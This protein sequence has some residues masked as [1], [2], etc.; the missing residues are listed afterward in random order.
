[1]AIAFGLTSLLE[2]LWKA[3][4]QDIVWTIWV[5]DRIFNREASVSSIWDRAMFLSGFGRHIAK[6]Y[7]GFSVANF[8]F[9]IDAVFLP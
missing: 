9:D 5:T 2:N 8:L 6:I 1:M 3:S 7:E 4:L